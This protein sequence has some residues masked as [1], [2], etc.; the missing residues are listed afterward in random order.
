MILKNI[1]LTNFRCFNELFIELHP[2]L[3]RGLE[4]IPN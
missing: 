3:N 4:R 2:R 1:K